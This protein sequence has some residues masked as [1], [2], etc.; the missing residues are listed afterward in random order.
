VLHPRLEDAWADFRR[1]LAR[2]GRS[3][4]TTGIYRAS[5]ET[6]WRWAETENLPPDP[7]KITYRDVN[8]WVDSMLAQP[9]VKGGHVQYEIDPETGEQ[10]PSTIA[11]NTVRIRW[12]NLRPFF[13]W[14]ATEMD[15]PSPFT[16][17]DPPRLAENPVRVISMH[18]VRLLLHACDGKDFEARRDT[19]L[20]RLLI[21]SGARVGEVVAMRVDSWDRRS[22][23]VELVGKTGTRVVP[24]SPSTGEALARYVRLRN[25]H[26]K[27]HLPA[28]WLGARGRLTAGG[29]TQ[30]LYRRCDQAG[31]PRI[32]PHI[33]RHTWAHEMKRAGAGE[34]D[35]MSLGGWS[36]PAMVHRYGKSAAVARA[37][38]TARRIAIGDEL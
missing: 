4:H 2:K 30:M 32:H 14:W 6:F 25:R 16:R 9:A 22:D 26:P 15:E 19:A 31:I 37:H 5:Y 34:G 24:V 1:S 20:I 23:V 11:A 18:D 8:A 17:A 38:E 28:L 3:E 35:L 13:S 21:D 27:E 36:T 12:Q 10:R 33:L 29:V 7:G